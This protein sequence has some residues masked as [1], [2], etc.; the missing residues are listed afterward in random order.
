M[1]CPPFDHPDVIE[2]N[3]NLVYELEKQIEPPDAIISCVGGGGLIGGIFQG[4]P[5]LYANKGLRNV[6]WGTGIALEVIDDSRS[7]RG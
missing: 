7:C 6:D 2:G 5:L 1:Y 3:A 4:T